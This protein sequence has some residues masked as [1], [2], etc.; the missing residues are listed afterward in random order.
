MNI[1]ETSIEITRDINNNP[2]AIITWNINNLGSVT[3]IVVKVCVVNL[4]Q[5]MAD[6]IRDLQSTSTVDIPEGQEYDFTFELYDGD[7]LVE[8]QG[9][10]MNLGSCILPSFCNTVKQSLLYLH[11]VQFHQVGMMMMEVALTWA[12]LVVL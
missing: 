1:D 8:T 10:T 6:L 3:H 2:V 5:C 12:V 11:C 7:Q 9:H 4:N